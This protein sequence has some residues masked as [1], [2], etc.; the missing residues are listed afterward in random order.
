MPRQHVPH[1]VPAGVAGH[2][3]LSEILAGA[4]PAPLPD[5]SPLHRGALSAMALPLKTFKPLKMPNPADFMADQM[6]A[7]LIEAMERGMEPDEIVMAEM[8]GEPTIKTFIAVLRQA[9]LCYLKANIVS[10]LRRLGRPASI[11]PEEL[12][13]EMYDAFVLNVRNAPFKLLLEFQRRLHPEEY[14]DGIW[15]PSHCS[16]YYTHK[17]FTTAWEQL[18]DVMAEEEDGAAMGDN[19]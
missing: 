11:I 18:P 1:K 4:P 7:W 13:H 3:F 14:A 17:D 6:R 19:V 5:G 10:E 2:F 16:Q 12:R 9:A 8:N 15:P